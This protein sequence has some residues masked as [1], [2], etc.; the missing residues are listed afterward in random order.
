MVNLRP[1]SAHKWVNCAGSP[2]AESA[3]PNTRSRIADEGTV[4]H[5]IAARVLLSSEWPTE[6]D[7]FEVLED[8]SVFPVL[9]DSDADAIKYTEEMCEAAVKY[10]TA[11]K[12]YA[13]FDELHVEESVNMSYLLGEGAQGTPDAWHYNLE[14]ETLTVHDLKYGFREIEAEGNWQLICY[15]F[16]ISEILR[17]LPVSSF[18]LVIHQPRLGGRVDEHTYSAEE[19]IQMARVVSVAAGWARTPDPLR[20]AGPWCTKYYCKAAADCPTLAEYVTEPLEELDLTNADIAEKLSKLDAIRQWCDQVEAEANRLVFDEGQTIPGYK[21][22]QGRAGNRQ[23]LDETEAERVLKSLKLKKDEMYV[24]KL[25]SPANAA[26]LANERNFTEKQT[27]KIE[28]LVSRAE[29]KLVL[30]PESDKRRAVDYKS[31]LKLLDN[32]D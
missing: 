18:R 28:A 12:S 3:Y 25:I 4:A 6:G 31:P 21:V 20:A 24:Y 11:I 7:E 15:A 2:L 23:W 19:L 10:T 14:T 17:A 29:G 5:H 16:S 1:S 22:V 32:L 8:G 13:G 27:G 26:K 9:L 30:A